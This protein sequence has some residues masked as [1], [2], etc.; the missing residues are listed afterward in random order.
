ME[1]NNL[2][3]NQTN[4]PGAPPTVT[5]SDYPA[6]APVLPSQPNNPPNYQ[7][8]SAPVFP[9]SLATYSEPKKS[10]KA[11]WIGLIVVLLAAIVGATFLFW[12]STQQKVIKTSAPKVHI[13]LVTLSG[14]ATVGIG[15]F[16]VGPGKNILPG[17]YSISS[18]PGQNGD[19]LIT[20]SGVSYAATLD[21]PASSGSRSGASAWAQLASGD[22]VK[23]SGASLKNVTFRPVVTSPSDPPALAKL[24]PASFTV[25]DDPDKVNPG[26]SFTFDDK[27]KNAF[28]LVI[29]PNYTVK[30][31]KPLNDTGFLM[32]LA[33]G[34]Q[35]GTVGVVS[36]WRSDAR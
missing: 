20:S 7:Q 16:T 6:V 36:G 31:N 15:T 26:K 8:Q 18:S 11:L 14:P 17:L 25:T 21:A 13:P 4:D 30:Y 33:D 3:P 12:P 34:D 29:S 19:L 1:D 23:I 9:P 5:S 27:D 22:T 32:E 35:V 24:Y 10:K 28:I 2:H